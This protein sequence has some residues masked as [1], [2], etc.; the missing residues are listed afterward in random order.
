MGQNRI[1]KVYSAPSE[2]FVNGH[3]IAKLELNGDNIEI[4]IP[5]G[6]LQE[7]NELVIKC[8]RNL[9]QSAYVD[10][11]DIEIANLRVEV[12]ERYNFARH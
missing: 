1:A 5:K 11:D 10:Y 3:R 9:F 4:L 2:V 7:E 8:G 12:K 6:L